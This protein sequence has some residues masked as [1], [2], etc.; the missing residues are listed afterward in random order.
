MIVLMGLA[1]NLL[2]IGYLNSLTSTR[3]FHYYLR[4]TIPM[5]QGQSSNA[6]VY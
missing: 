2:R 6:F 1:E 3:R 5:N 4:V